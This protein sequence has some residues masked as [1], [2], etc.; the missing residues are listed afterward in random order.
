M[1]KWNARREIFSSMPIR[2]FLTFCLSVAF[3]FAAV[4]AVNDLFDLEHSDARRLIVKV[5]TSAVFAV[6]WIMILHRRMT[7]GCL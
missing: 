2:S 7:R 4:G 5:L 1:N 3:T 6:V